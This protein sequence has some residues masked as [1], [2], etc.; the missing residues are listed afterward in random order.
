MLLI[1]IAAYELD[2]LTSN[3]Q[4][5]KVE[6]L[7]KLTYGLILL[8]Q[9]GQGKVVYISVW[10]WLYTCVYIAHTYINTRGFPVDRKWCQRLTMR[11]SSLTLHRQSSGLSVPGYQN[12]MCT[13]S[14]WN[15]L[16]FKNGCENTCIHLHFFFLLGFFL[17][18]SLTLSLLCPLLFS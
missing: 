17:F 18:L 11:A 4:T 13:A 14:H 2:H 8:Q 9:K 15:Y 3:K 5:L 16:L 6:F 7:L 1:L 10:L 12:G